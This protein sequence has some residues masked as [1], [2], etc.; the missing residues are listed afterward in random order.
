MSAKKQAAIRRKKREPEKDAQEILEMLAGELGSVFAFHE[1]KSFNPA[2][3][4]DEEGSGGPSWADEAEEVALHLSGVLPSEGPED[5]IW[6]SAF[7][8]GCQ[9]MKRK[10]EHRRFALIMLREGEEDEEDQEA[11]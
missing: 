7:G 1:D 11:V 6:W 4:V 8:R 5:E 2:F 10:L 9:Q 3:Q